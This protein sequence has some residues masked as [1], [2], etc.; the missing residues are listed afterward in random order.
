MFQNHKSNA[1]LLFKN[2][3]TVGKYEEKNIYT[4]SILYFPQVCFYIC[5]KHLKNKFLLKSA[6]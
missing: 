6:L 2:V 1:C 4:M 5:S 3:G